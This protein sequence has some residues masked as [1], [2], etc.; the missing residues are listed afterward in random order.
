LLLLFYNTATI[1]VHS[2]LTIRRDIIDDLIGRLTPVSS[3][4][5]Y[6]FVDSVKSTQENILHRTPSLSFLTTV[7]RALSYVRCHSRGQVH[8]KTC[9][10]SALQTPRRCNPERK[11]STAVP[12]QVKAIFWLADTYAERV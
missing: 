2:S 7:T 10:R 6:T 5:F 3:L 11:A 12:T 9:A 4:L 8:C 1:R